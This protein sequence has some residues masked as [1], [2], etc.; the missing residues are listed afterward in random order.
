[1][2]DTGPQTL[3]RATSG[4]P[5]LSTVVALLIIGWFL[6]QNE[7]A[8][9]HLLQAVP[10]W[11]DLH[12]NGYF[13][14]FLVAL[15]AL[16]LLFDLVR[17]RRR[18]RLN[19]ASLARLQTEN[20]DLWQH[21]RQL[22]MKVKTYSGHADKLK[23]FISD[24]LLEYIEYDEK[25][26][27]FQSIAAEVRH[28]GVIAFDR[29]Q[30]ALTEAEQRLSR[31]DSP[32]R[33]TDFQSAG[34]QMRYLWDL[35]DLAT[36]DNLSL[37][38]GN[39]QARCEEQYYQKLL[40]PEDAEPFEPDYHPHDAA[41]QSV[42]PLLDPS[43][44]AEQWHKAIANRD[45]AQYLDD[46][47]H[48]RLWLSPAG[49]LLGKRNH[50]VLLLDNL[51]KN[52]Q[53]YTHKKTYQ[54]K[55]QRVSV[56][57]DEVDGEIR[58]R[59]QT[60]LVEGAP[61]V[62]TESTEQ[63]DKAD[64]TVAWSLRKPVGSIQITQADSGD[65]HTFVLTDLEAEQRLFDPWSYRPHWVLTVHPRKSGCRVVFEPLDNR[66]VAFEVHLPTAEA[67]LDSTE[68]SVELDDIDDEMAR[69]NEPFAAAQPESQG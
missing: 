48:I 62:Q 20:Q 2:T 1:M 13:N 57:L 17:Y 68:S 51:L 19:Q 24:K 4:F 66:G 31:F 56:A 60:T 63:A 52:A 38:I 9:N 14:H 47:A 67:R 7:P 49:H 58:L 30:S 32:T 5:W 50:L 25:F 3:P 6:V 39:L 11:L 54:H 33:S 23:L 21:R 22:Q 26:L 44:P 29:V 55:H 8:L 37:H 46:D 34:E 36:T 64:K 10:G 41:W 15:Y 53:F 59:V 42:R 43:T 16:C 69:L 40:N 35:L 12:L 28:N 18:R 45:T 61:R 27:H 65:Q